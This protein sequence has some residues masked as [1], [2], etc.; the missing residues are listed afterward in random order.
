MMNDIIRLINGR[1]MKDSDGFNS[2]AVVS[3]TE[4]F[5]EIGSPVRSQRDSALQHGYVAT[6][7][8][9]INSAEYNNEGWVEHDGRTYEVKESFRLSDDRL[10]LTCSDAR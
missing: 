1:Y 4:V 10:E 2:L 8:A 3:S 6:L 5:A 9:V 7:K